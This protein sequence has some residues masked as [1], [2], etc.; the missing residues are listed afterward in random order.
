MAVSGVQASTQETTPPEVRQLVTFKFQ[1]GKTGEALAVYRERAIPLYEQNP[2]MLSFRGFG[3]VESPEAL[4]LIVVSTFQGMAG[5]DA[6]NAEL[7]AEAARAGTSIGAVYGAI[8]SLSTS[9]HDQF[10][11]ML[12]PLTNGDPTITR[13]V[14]LVSYQLVPG[15]GAVFEEALRGTIVEWE[16]RAGIPSATGRFLISDGWHYLRFI[17]FES[18]GA[19][20]EYWSRLNSEADYGTIAR[21]TVRTK[22]IVVA[23]IPELAVR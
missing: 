12:E 15:A 1:P 23:P 4:D 21:L 17:G 2:S 10:V 16:K 3:E 20:H 11:E 6:S 18:L 22:E 7:R 5:M 13:L 14:A 9:H 8:G 19:Y